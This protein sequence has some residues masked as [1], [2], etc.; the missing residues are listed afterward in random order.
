MSVRAEGAADGGVSLGRVEADGVAFPPQG[1]DLIGDEAVDE[2]AFL[3]SRSLEV[4]GCEGSHNVSRSDLIRSEPVASLASSEES[5][6]DVG[7]VF[8]SSARC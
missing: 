6:D 1:S 4:T 7:V 8:L 5:P 3:P 2:L